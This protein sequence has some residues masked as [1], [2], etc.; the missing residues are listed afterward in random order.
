M[1]RVI[2]MAFV[3]TMATVLGLAWWPLPT[4]AVVLAASGVW[5]V[6]S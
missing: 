2:V 1:N 4:A 6:R 5:V 3:L